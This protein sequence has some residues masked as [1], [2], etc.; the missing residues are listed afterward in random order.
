MTLHYSLTYLLTI[1]ALGVIVGLA[2]LLWPKPK[3]DK[4][5]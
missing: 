5:P 2:V 1:T 4:H 3:G